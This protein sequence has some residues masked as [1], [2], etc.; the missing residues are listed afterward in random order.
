MSPY[1][2]ECDNHI[3][4]SIDLDIYLPLVKKSTRSQFDD[5][6]CHENKIKTKPWNWSSMW[7]ELYKYK[8]LLCK[9]QSYSYSSSTFWK[10]SDS[11]Y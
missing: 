11:V 7:S 3:L 9:K 5:R 8:K 6:R 10:L 1:Q 2:Q 4:K